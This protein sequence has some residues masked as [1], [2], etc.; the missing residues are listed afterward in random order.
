MNLI[1]V[2]LCLWHI[3]GQSRC[4]RGWLMRKIQIVVLVAALLSCGAG[5]AQVHAP[6]APPDEAPQTFG[7]WVL[8]CG[9]SAGERACEVT[10]TV[11]LPGETAPIAR[12]AFGRP[13]QPK[14][15][16]QAKDKDRPTR[17]V[18]LVPVNVSIAPGVDLAPDAAK[19][20]L[21]IPFKSCIPAACFAEVEL[22]DDQMQI[23]RNESQPGQLV[24][25]DTAG[26]PVPVEISFNGLD[27]ALDAL[28][29]R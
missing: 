23:F 11:K 25:T 28:A 26:K 29:K 7:D 9:S 24:F 21:N 16:A 8:H 19:P 20:H 2:S 18:V 22:S 1:L 12:L 27:Q 5:S 3:H 15:K 10:A 17:L 4:D 13:V 6:A 14:G